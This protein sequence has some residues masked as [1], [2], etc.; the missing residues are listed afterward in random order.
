MSRFYKFPNNGWCTDATHSLGKFLAKHLEQEFVVPGEL[1][2]AWNAFSYWPITVS[3]SKPTFK[4]INLLDAVESDE[5][6]MRAKEREDVTREFERIKKKNLSK[7]KKN[8]FKHEGVEVGSLVKLISNKYPL[9][10]LGW[11]GRVTEF[12]SSG[13]RAYVHGCGNTDTNK[14]VVY[15]II[16]K[17]LEAVPEISALPSFEEAPLQ[18]DVDVLTGLVNHQDGRRSAMLQNPCAEIFCGEGSIGNQLNKPIKILRGTRRIRFMFRRS[19]QKSFVFDVD[20]IEP[21]ITVLKN[22]KLF[23]TRR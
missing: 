7:L 16:T 5:A 15:G 1:G 21:R 20:S 14:N 19:T 8:S 6:I 2:Y 18:I 10:E 3:S 22:R 17:D 12:N 4:M 23:L 13:S 9:L 11:T